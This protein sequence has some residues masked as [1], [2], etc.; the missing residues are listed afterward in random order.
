MG[1]RNG[2]PRRAAQ[3]VAEPRRSTGRQR[4]GNGRRRRPR[5]PLPDAAEARRH[6]LGHF[7]GAKGRRARFATDL[8]ESV[9]WGDERNAQL[10]DLV[11]KLVAE[12]GWEPPEIPEPEPFN[13]ESP[14]EVNLDGF[15]AVV[16]AAGFRPDYESWVRF[17]GAFDELGFPIHEEGASTVVPGLYFVGVH[18]LRKRRSAL[19]NG[20]GE[21]PPSWPADRRAKRPASRN[22][23]TSPTRRQPEPPFEA[24]RHDRN[25]N[26][27]R[28]RSTRRER[29]SHEASAPATSSRL[30][31]WHRGVG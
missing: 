31:A 19:L 13:G 29:S 14:E 26:S 11:R 20:V 10:T 17:P 18:F 25:P 30:E 28:E 7:L 15:G 12:R 22:V 23:K 16:F 6:P 27:K 5:P 1:A 3:L 4:A 21:M 8:G 9:A 24:G 2:V